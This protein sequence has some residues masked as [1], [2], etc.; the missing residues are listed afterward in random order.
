MVRLKFSWS[1]CIGKK[2]MKSCVDEAMTRYRLFHFLTRDKISQLT[3]TL[4]KGLDDYKRTSKTGQTGI[5]PEV[6]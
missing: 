6:P 2:K 1:S 3:L 5:A 4:I